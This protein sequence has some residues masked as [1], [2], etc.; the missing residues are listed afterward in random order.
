MQLGKA[1]WLGTLL[2]EAVLRHDPAAAAAV[3]EPSPGG[4]SPEARARS[5]LRRALRRTGLL[6]GTPTGADGGFS[7]TAPEEQLFLAVVRTYARIALDIAAVTAAPSG[8]RA[9]QLAFLFATLAGDLR[10]SEE[11]GKALGRKGGGLSARALARLESALAE[12]AMSLGGDP[13]YGLVLHNAAVFEDAQLFGR[14]AVD[15]FVRGEVKRADTERRL[16]V[17]AQR[18]AILVEVL[19]ALSCAERPPSFPARRAILRQIEDLGLPARL[20]DPLARRVKRAFER[21][22]SLEAIVKPVRSAELRRFILEQTLLASLVD[23]HRS[24]T[25]LAFIQKLAALFEMEGALGRIEL[26][27]AEFY[28]QNR[29]VVDVFTVAAGADGMGEELVESMQR[30]LEKNFQALL[31]E[32]RETGELSVLLTRAARGQALT[33]AEWRQ[34]RAQLVDIAK[35]IP[36]LAIFAAPG[37]VLLLVALAKVLPFNLLPSA[38]QD[39]APE[40]PEE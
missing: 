18:K 40:R 21:P 30:T 12:R 3:L 32:I 1:G 39:P 16:A 10:L 8:P 35:A 7:T 25:E 17:F 2:T 11:L 37:G 34:A 28:A 4:L 19:V 14:Q 13:V 31:T 9:Q 26:E 22:P 5:Y 6:Y 27:M 33:A 38:F 15:L 20:K 24:Q 36:A 23:G 29:S